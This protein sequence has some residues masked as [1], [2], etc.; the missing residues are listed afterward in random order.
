MAHPDF[1]T[2]ESALLAAFSTGDSD[3]IDFLFK[4]FYLSLVDYAMHFTGNT[5]E[6]EDVVAETY[7]KLLKK[8]TSFAGLQQ[9]KNFLF[10]TVRN[11]CIDHLRELKV[12]QKYQ[13]EATYLSNASNGGES[14]DYHRMDTE[15]LQIIAEEIDRLPQRAKEIFSLIFFQKKSLKEVAE[16]MDVHV[17]TIKYEKTKALEKL[18][19]TLSKKD[20]L[21]IPIPA[22]FMFLFCLDVF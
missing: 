20:L 2:N 3:A 18:R 1:D 15:V 12:N 8:T 22:Y 7:L 21:D 11:A 14:Y 16:M 19:L 6:A 17:N 5:Q 4:K 9:I 10:L 13:R